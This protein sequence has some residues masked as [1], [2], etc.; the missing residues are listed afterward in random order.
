MPA[1]R[2]VFCGDRKAVRPYANVVHKWC[3]NDREA[4]LPKSTAVPTLS[5]PDLIALDVQPEAEVQVRDIRVEL[6]RRCHGSAS[7]F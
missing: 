1:A 3:A 5:T 7:P 4:A 2:Y 6:K